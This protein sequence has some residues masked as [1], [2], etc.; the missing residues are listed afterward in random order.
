MCFCSEFTKESNA[1]YNELSVTEYFYEVEKVQLSNSG[2]YQCIA[3]YVSD[4]EIVP[5]GQTSSEE[6]TV[7]VLGVY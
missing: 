3:D 2:L 6:A 5:A 1:L 7:I 4:G